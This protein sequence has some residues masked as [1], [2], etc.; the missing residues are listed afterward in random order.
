[1]EWVQI[2]LW[3]DFSIASHSSYNTK[4]CF[5]VAEPKTK[6]A[7]KLLKMGNLEIRNQKE[8][9]EKNNMNTASSRIKNCI[10]LQN[11]RR[12]ILT[13]KKSNRSRS[14]SSNNGGN[15]TFAHT[16]THAPRAH[17]ACTARIKES[18][19]TGGKTKILSRQIIIKIFFF[20]NMAKFG[21]S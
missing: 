18:K 13:I 14:N 21:L 7:T 2:F 3:L 19:L 17:S 11:G 6:S 15:N 9:R 10:K 16:H 20:L 8:K 5:I 12:I 1:M 4:S